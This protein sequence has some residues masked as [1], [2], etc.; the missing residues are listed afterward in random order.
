MSHL[1]LDQ[2]S[3]STPQILILSDFDGTMTGMEGKS[4]VTN[5]FY[6]QLFNGGQLGGFRLWA[7]KN[8]E[9]VQ[10]KFKKGFGDYQRYL[11]NPEAWEEDKDSEYYGLLIPPKVV[12][13]YKNRLKDSNTKLV[14]LTRN[15]ADYVIEVLK[16][17]GFTE[18]ELKQ[19]K[20][21]AV[22]N[23][24]GAKKNFAKQVMQE[25]WPDEQKKT[26]WVCIYDDSSKDRESMKVAVKERGDLN[27]IAPEFNPA[28]LNTEE[29]EEGI[30]TILQLASSQPT[31]NP[32]KWSEAISKLKARKQAPIKTDSQVTAIEHDSSSPS[33][34]SELPFYWRDTELV[35]SSSDSASLR[36]S[37][38][39]ESSSTSSPDFHDC[40]L[41][42]KDKEAILQ[43][44]HTLG[45][46]RDSFFCMNK[47]RKEQKIEALTHLLTKDFC[48]SDYNSLSALAKDILKVHPEANKGLLSNRVGDLLTRF[49]QGKHVDDEERS[50][51]SWGCF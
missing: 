45:R 51:F 6:K 34:S 42:E 32:D 27:L 30:R 9:E 8:S 18:D 39:S 28:E 29:C 11:N 1:K 31:K 3:I 22:G 4:T 5:G 44:I 48:A 13:F 16:Y 50:C 47:D 49:A 23:Q 38:N 21:E 40:Y 46:E 26:K 35:P 25:T 24:S 37:S 43:L 36:S 14:I 19:I 12:K 17:H 2:Q 20:T 41:N 33:D 15:R 10:S 7:L